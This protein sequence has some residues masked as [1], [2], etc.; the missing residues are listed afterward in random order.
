MNDE[1]NKKEHKLKVA[2]LVL[3]IISSV[4]TIIVNIIKAFK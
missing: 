1:D 4:I 3:A 2:S